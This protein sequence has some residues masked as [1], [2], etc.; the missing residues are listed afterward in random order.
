MNQQ[1]TSARHYLGGGGVG[2]WKDWG[3]EWSVW[4]DWITDDTGKAVPVRLT[5]SGAPFDPWDEDSIAD[6]PCTT[7]PIGVI[8]REVLDRLPLRDMLEASREQMLAS[9]PVEL[10]C[11]DPDA[12]VDV[13][14]H[15]GRLTRAAQVHAQMVATG[16][17]N[18]SQATRDQ[19]DREGV[20]PGRR[21]STEPANVPLTETRVR[22]WIAEARKRGLYP[23]EDGRK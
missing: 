19:L 2:S 1:H 10:D 9:G 23:G 15:V 4:V 21:G 12:F 6:L 11:V 13:S 17:R 3:V 18:P 14:T 20:R 7:E 5:L 22:T 8:R 16:V